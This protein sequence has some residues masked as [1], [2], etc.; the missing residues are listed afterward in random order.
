[1]EQP[2]YLRDLFFI[3]AKVWPKSS[4]GKRVN[5]TAVLTTLYLLIVLAVGFFT[6]RKKGGAHEFFVAGAQLRWPL[7][8]PFLAAEYI[9]GSTTVG[10]AEKVHKSGI[11]YLVYYVAA[12]VGMALL[13]FCFAKFYHSIK[14]MTVG[15]AFGVLFDRRARLACA[16][17]II[18]LYG[19]TQATASQGLATTIAPMFN[20]SYTSATWIS[21]TLLVLLG[22]WGL[23]GQAWMNVIHFAAIII[24]FVPLAVASVGAVGGMGK[25]VASVPPGYLNPAEGGLANA[26]SLFTS[27]VLI[28]LIS[29]T[30]ITAMFAAR[31]ETDAKIGAIS[32]GIFVL[33][34]VAAPALMGLAAYVIAPNIAS[35]DALWVI[36]EHLGT[37]GTAMA[38]IGVLAAIVSTTPAAFLGLGAMATRDLFLLVRPKASDKAQVIFCRIAVAI[39]GFGG[40]ALAVV[41]VNVAGSI[42]SVV[43]GSVAVRAV[44]TVPLIVSV[45]W[46]R[47]H[48][49]AAF[50]SIVSGVVTGVTWLFIG[51]PLGLEPLWPGLVASI[52]TLII[53]SLV[54][55]PAP[56]RGVEGL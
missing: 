53:V 34:F 33:C 18:V 2:I 35:K 41:L 20:I 29:V 8:I 27:A 15:E 17:T 28:K 12:P 1:M 37:W 10:I 25:L 16:L 23:R 30:A 43:F 6:S 42:L 44:I 14:K 4:G 52:L 55:K 40:T 39:I 21:A 47:V 48:P 22:I 51:S 31:S 50:L 3:R 26:S 38:S 49:T 19:I 46:R 13:A 36:S 45:L 11:A 24:A 5:I 9:S 32:T 54:K 56:Y 7:L